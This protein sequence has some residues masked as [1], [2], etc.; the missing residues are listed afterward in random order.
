MAYSASINQQPQSSLRVAFI[1]GRFPVLSEAFILNQISGLLEQGHQIDIYALE[2]DSGETKVHPIVSQYNLFTRAYYSPQIPD[3]YSLRCFKA[4]GLL[5][6]QSWKN[7]LVVLKSLNVFRYGKQAASL[8]L[9][10]GAVA[11][12]KSGNYDIIHCQFGI[13]ALQGKYPEDAGVLVLRSLGLLQGKLIVA[14]RGWDISWYIKEQGER[15]Y[16]ELFAT[17]DFFVTNCNFFRDRAIKLGCASEK[18]VVLGSGIDCAKFSFKSRKFPAT[19]LVRLVTT[20]RLI[21]KKGIEYGIRAVAMLLEQYSDVEYQIIGDGCLREALQ[22]LINQLGIAEKVKLLGW[23]QQ[24][25]IIEILDH[26]HIFIAPCVTARDGNQDAP[27]NTLKE[28]MAMGLPVIATHHGG[29]PELVTDGVSGLLVPERDTRAIAEKLQYLLANP[30]I[31][32][33]MGLNGRKFVE[34]HYD[35]KQLN[36][37]LVTIYNRVIKTSSDTPV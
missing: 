16:E 3:N 19:G 25:E 5:I 27:V 13:Y 32:Q 12:L 11:F 29:I 30:Q 34:Q 17:A 33:D 22:Q 2:G 20:G 4:L 23:R 10:Y 28:A 37:E 6:T 36:Q 31:W 21:E 35:I 15:V 14:F 9:F 8:R 26:S 18:I 24:Q 7:P 1:V